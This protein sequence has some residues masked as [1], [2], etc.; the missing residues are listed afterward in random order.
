MQ[1]FL[2]LRSVFRSRSRFWQS[3]GGGGAVAAGF[4]IQVGVEG[5]L[6]PGRVGT[7]WS[8]AE[9]AKHELN[10]IELLKRK[11]DD[12]EVKGAKAKKAKVTDNTG[13]RASYEFA[14]AVDDVVL[15]IGSRVLGVQLRARNGE[16]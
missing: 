10:I 1:V 16:S 14:L 4:V 5:R 9:R 8:G 11:A 13:S 7:Q 15:A 12:A 6:R 3:R 2:F